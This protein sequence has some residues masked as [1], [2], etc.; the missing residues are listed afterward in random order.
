MIP[1]NNK[2]KFIEKYGNLW[3]LREFDFMP[4]NL[5]DYHNNLTESRMKIALSEPKKWAIY[6]N[7]DKALAASIKVRV[8]L[9][10]TSVL[11]I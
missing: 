8:A 10:L 1:K 4:E 2:D 6:D 9:G 7:Y 11:T 5:A 3:Y